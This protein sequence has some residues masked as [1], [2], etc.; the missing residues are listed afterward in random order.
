[1]AGTRT[2]SKIELAAELPATGRGTWRD[3]DTPGLE[4]FGN[5]AGAGWYL[6]H[7]IAGRRVRDQVGRWPGLDLKGARAA[8]AALVQAGALKTAAGGDVLADR[9]A[10]KAAAARRRGAITLESA[11][12]GDEKKGIIGYREDRLSRL[13]SGGHSER[14]IRLVFG[15]LLEKSLADLTRNDLVAA[16]ARKRR[17]APA[18][19]DTAI[20]YA[21]P[22]FGWIAASGY[23]E[24]LLSDVKAAQTRKRERTLTL[25]ELGRIV[26]AVEAMGARSGPLIV[27]TL[28][29][30][31]GRA[32]EVAGMRSAEVDVR[33][34]LWTLPAERNKGARV[35][36]VPL[37][38]YAIAAIRAGSG[39]ELVFPGNTGVTPFSGWSRLKAAIDAGSGVESW[40]FHDFRR[41]F[42]SICAD[43]GVDP[44]TADRCLNHVAANALGTVARI[45]QRSAMIDQRRAALRIWNEAIEEAKALAL[46]H[47]ADGK[48]RHVR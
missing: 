5:K 12:A 18:T 1:M 13:R 36:H 16:I 48:V 20:R 42:A 29:A 43:R 15:D 41:T 6:R 28:L 24:N 7:R 37:N 33:G 35:H 46:A 25:L 31:A 8:A 44:V 32:N 39:G 10:K 30:T 4:L 22:F 27:R 2:P 14:V 38:E 45:Y 3:V 21:K 17:S 40:V 9:T 34:C 47:G 23:G 11:L 19:A 26:T